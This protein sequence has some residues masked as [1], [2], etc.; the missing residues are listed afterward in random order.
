MLTRPEYFLDLIVTR[1]RV[2]SF[3]TY[4]YRVTMII[5]GKSRM[6]VRK[7]HTCMYMYTHLFWGSVQAGLEQVS[8]AQCQD[9]LGS[10]ML[11][12]PGLQAGARTGGRVLAGLWGLCGLCPTP[13]SD[14]VPAFAATFWPCE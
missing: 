6:G 8:G 10:M 11:Y 3:Q 1:I 13:G 7:A 12:K 9:T 4:P 2:A 14:P 5:L